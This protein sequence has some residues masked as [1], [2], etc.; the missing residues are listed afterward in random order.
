MTPRCHLADLSSY[1]NDQTIS[2]FSTEPLLERRLGKET[3]DRV[4]PVP[5]V[6]RFYNGQGELL[7]VGKAKNLRTRLFSYK[8]A[9]PGQ[10]SRKVSRMIGE[11]RSFVYIETETERDALLLENRMIRG[12]RPP[13]NHA[14]KETETYYFVYLRPG[15]TGLEFRLAMRIHD[16][17]E[18][19]YWHG[20]FKGHA[21]VRHSLGCL[22]RLL[23]MAEH[24][25]TDPMHIPVKL[26]R[27]LT[28]MRFHLPWQGE[29]S[30]SLL[31]GMT[32]LL[33]CWITGED[34]ELSDWLAVQIEAGRRLTLFQQLW[35]EYHLDQINR[36]FRYKLTRHYNLRNG[37]KQIPQDE[38]DD[39]LV[40]V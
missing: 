16:D 3:F 26:N 39:L 20:C 19:K 2:L 30:P 5:G 32:D 6:Y 12:D 27:N 33:H 18:Q 8:R 13:Y 10:V 36:F 15:P 29:L 34:D 14:N 11:I 4:P 35:L 22:L 9:K 37:R 31:T 40:K 23:W 1:M 28:P 38:L 17:T 24:G 7:Y 21:P 25:V